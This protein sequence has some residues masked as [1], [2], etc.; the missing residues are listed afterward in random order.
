MNTYFQTSKD[1]NLFSSML[2]AA[3]FVALV[4]VVLFAPELAYAAGD[5]AASQKV[6]TFFDQVIKILKGAS[7]AIVTIA[8]M[9]AGYQVAFAH[10]RITDV[11]PVL[12]G[13]LVVGGAAQFAALLLE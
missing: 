11:A 5:S 6:D 2:P 9:F 13:G 8:F 1:K 10:K 12:I 7:I 4:A 3:A